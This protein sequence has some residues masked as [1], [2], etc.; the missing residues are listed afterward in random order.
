MVEGAFRREL[1]AQV[2][3]RGDSA[4]GRREFERQME[5]RQREDGKGEWAALRQGWF[6]RW[7]R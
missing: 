2:S 1:Q 5:T 6:F 7:T 4:A 3:E